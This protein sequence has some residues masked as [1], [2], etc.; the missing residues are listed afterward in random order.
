M[1]FVWI[2]WILE[3]LKPNKEWLYY[4]FVK[5]VLDHLESWLHLYT[6]SF[7]DIYILWPWCFILCWQ[8]L[9]HCPK[10]SSELYLLYMVIVRGKGALHKK[11]DALRELRRLLS[12]SEFP[13]VEAAI[14]A[15][16]VGL[17]V[18]CLSFGSPDEQVNKKF[19]CLH[20]LL[21]HKFW[22]LTPVDIR[23]LHFFGITLGFLLGH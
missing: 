21:L 4:F 3:H 15:G 10:F 6:G 7:L 13:P 11:V 5:R 22:M 14:K 1:V 8:S 12:R 9:A 18:Q 17:L 20:H 2:D 19:P 16:A 23:V